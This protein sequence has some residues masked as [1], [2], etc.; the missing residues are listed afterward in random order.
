MLTE[1]DRLV[2]VG[3]TPF[4]SRLAA[5]R[6]EEKTLESTALS[7]IMAAPVVSKT[8]KTSYCWCA[9]RFYYLFVWAWLEHA[10]KF[11]RT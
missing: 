1:H 7:D 11:C 10:C 4:L 8:N 3:G 9:T 2:A 5:S 6:K